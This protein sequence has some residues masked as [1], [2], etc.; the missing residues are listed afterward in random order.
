MITFNQLPKIYGPPGSLFTQSSDRGVCPWKWLST[1]Q[2][3]LKQ[4]KPIRIYSL[5][6][7]K[8]IL[9]LSSQNIETCGRGPFSEDKSHP[10]DPAVN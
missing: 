2:N 6:S 8:D 10:S 5:I 3:W 4:N 7:F 9:R 1:Y